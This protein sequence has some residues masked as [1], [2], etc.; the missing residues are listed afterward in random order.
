M[1]SLIT[2]GV[3]QYF[4]TNYLPG[5][6]TL[7]IDLTE[8]LTINLRDTLKIYIMDS[9]M[10]L[11]QKLRD[12]YEGDSVAWT[13]SVSG[14]PTGADPT[15]YTVKLDITQDGVI[16]QTLSGAVDA[17]SNYSI[18][19]TLT[20]DAGSYLIYVSIWWNDGTEKSDYDGYFAKEVKARPAA[21]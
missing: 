5:A 19:D 4:K 9:T 2:K 21:A 14:L 17:D 8:N 6:G 12:W 10:A 1:I 16:K 7:K 13:D 11:N 18:S 15:D 20:I 3:L